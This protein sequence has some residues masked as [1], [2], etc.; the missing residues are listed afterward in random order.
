MSDV[1]AGGEAILAC[2]IAT[3]FMNILNIAVVALSPFHEFTSLVLCWKASKKVVSRYGV[4]EG[5]RKG[6]AACALC[7]L[8]ILISRASLYAI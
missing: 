3:S 7:E 1:S 6:H 5:Q 2:A 8:S 4:L